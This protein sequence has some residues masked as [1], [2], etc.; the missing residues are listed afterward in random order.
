LLL[1]G[2][3]LLR[4][5]I[6]RV[7][8]AGLVTGSAALPAPEGRHSAILKVYPHIPSC[9]ISPPKNTCTGSGK[10]SVLKYVLMMFS[11]SPGSQ[12]TPRERPL[13]VLIRAPCEKS[14]KQPRFV[15]FSIFICGRPFSRLTG[16]V[17]CFVGCIIYRV[18][19]ACQAGKLSKIKPRNL[20][21]MRMADYPT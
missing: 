21:N 7:L 1:I 10:N 14:Q 12:V 3:Y 11:A 8:L 20:C 17:G 5:R 15:I 9:P 4:L 2:L 6:V 18:L 13:S 16:R 19:R